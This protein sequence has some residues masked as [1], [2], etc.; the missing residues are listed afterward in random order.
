MIGPMDSK[1]QQQQSARR[2]Q[3]DM[4][5]NRL[6]IWFA[7]AIGYE[8][9]VLLVKRFYVNFRTTDFEINLALGLGAVFGVFQWVGLALAAGAAVWLVISKKRGK[10]W[11][12]P[13]ILTAV[14]FVLWFT[15]VVTYRF[16]YSGGVDLLGI[17]A[18]AAAILSMIYYLYQRE[19]FCNAV[20]AGCG[21][22]CLWLYRRYF[23]VHPN[24]IRAGYVLAWVLL[25]AA[26]AVFWKLSQSGGKWNKHRV[27]PE[28]ISYVPAYATCGLTAA[29]LA[30]ALIG[31]S[32]A[33]F[34]AIFV[35]VIWLFC[36][37]VYY[38][39]RLM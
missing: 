27:F 5:L 35:L 36:M 17:V 29:V 20:I 1:K 12:K 23:Q 24:V 16:G 39:V 22:F 30:A 2:K 11:V 25:A 3:E 14:L 31:G 6:L 7:I 37:A 19:F 28:K 13:A 9:L 15:A 10:P 34:Y 8:A 26:A 33:A 4:A 32:A 18:P 21:I 38:T